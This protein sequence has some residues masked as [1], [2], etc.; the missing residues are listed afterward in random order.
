MLNRRFAIC[1][2]CRSQ[3]FGVLALQGSSQ[4]AARRWTVVSRR[5]AHALRPHQGAFFYVVHGV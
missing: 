2:Q 3:A 1:H 5:G 4:V